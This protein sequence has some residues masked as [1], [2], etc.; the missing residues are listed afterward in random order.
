MSM[1][2]VDQMSLKEQL[3][4]LIM[5]DIRYF[6]KTS[7]GTFAP[8]TVLP[9]QIKDF[10]NKYPVG[11][12]TL[13]RENLTK[14]D[15]IVNL[16]H[17]IAKSS[18]F[19]RF[20]GIDQEGGI[21]TRIAGAT[22]MPGNMALGAINSLEIT[23]KASN[24]I[25]E[26]LNALGINLNFAPC[27]D[28]NSNPQNPIIGTRSFGQ[29]PELV[30]AHGNAFIKGLHE[31]NIISCVKHFP[32]H[33]NV[34]TDTHVGE[35]YVDSSA[36][37]IEKCDLQPFMAAIKANVD[38]IMTAHIV[39][40]RL[41]N[42]RIYSNKAQAEVGT[43]T[44]FSKII[45]TKM[46]RQYMGYTGVIASD[47]L[48]MM[49]ITQYFEPVEA[50]ILAIKAGIDLILMPLHIWDNMGIQKFIDYF[51]HVA[52]ICANSPELKDRVRESCIRIIKL[53]Q[54]KLQAKNEITLDERNKLIKEV[55]G[56]ESHKK[57][58]YEIASKAITLYKNAKKIL[59]WKSTKE[60][61]IL[62]ISANNITALV[63]KEKLNNLGYNNITIQ[64]TTDEIAETITKQIEVSDKVIVLTYN[65][66][67]PDETLDYLFNRLNHFYKPYVM[68]SCRNPYDIMYVKDVNTN[69]LVYG[70][71]GMDQTNYH[72]RNFTLNLDAAVAKIM[73]ATDI[74]EFNNHCPVDLEP[75]KKDPRGDW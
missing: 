62:V 14:L 74:S 42:N 17:D 20:I 43:P 10:L 15:D 46:L 12:I 61:K 5:L 72:V 73:T 35:T 44:T 41:D 16:T 67:K 54:Q 47:A 9:E 45:L 60:D 31:Q 3:L 40:P 34:E 36:V 28:V 59:P 69:V 51:N 8:V 19:G 48:D 65:I 6:G 53:K 39:A 32:G 1:D 7:S 38:I 30:A 49:A 63:V 33:G 70:V 11:G 50:T 75:K 13:F 52:H 64:L 57:F 4:E 29:N 22:E 55:V 23:Q 27:L 25:G 18:K 24:I 68:L 58:E 26:E 56:S 37:E 2:T 71:T 21:V 66:T